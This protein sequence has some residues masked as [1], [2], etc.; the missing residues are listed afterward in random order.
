MS[1]PKNIQRDGIWTDPRSTKLIWPA[2]SAAVPAS[3]SVNAKTSVHTDAAEVCIEDTD[4]ITGGTQVGAGIYI[5]PPVGDNTPYR[6]KASLRINQSATDFSTYIVIGYGPVSPTGSADA[7]VIPLR[8]PFKDSIDELFMVPALDSGD[9]YFGR[10]LF[11]GI[12]L[13]TG[14]T[15]TNKR[16]VAHLSVQ[17]LGISP[18]TMQNAV[19]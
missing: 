5:N 15:I 7:I 19:S 4:S 6:V 11:V 3:I 1:A 17:S 8:T 9:A 14:T 12:S 13:E 2:E 18:P 16:I 10:P